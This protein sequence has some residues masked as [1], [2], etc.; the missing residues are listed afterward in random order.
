MKP[1]EIK[2]IAVHAVANAQRIIG[3]WLPDGKT[4]GHEYLARNPKRADSTP[5]S[6]SINVRTGEWADFATGDKGKDLVS[7]VAYLTDSTQSK[8]AEEVALFLGIPIEQTRP[9]NR[10]KSTL[11]DA[12]K[13]NASTEPKESLSGQSGKDSANDGWVC[14]M[15]IP[16]SAPLPPEAHPKHG[17]PDHRYPYLSIDGQVNYYHDRY[18]P[19]EADS[20]KQFA[21]LTL[22]KKNN[23]LKWQ[24]KAPPVPRPLY[25][26]P[27]LLQYPD[28]WVWIVEGE[29]AAS[30]LGKLL[31]DHPVLCWQGGS[32]AVDKSDFQ[33]LRGRRVRI[34]PD[35]DRPGKELLRI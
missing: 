1:P 34:W 15:P 17:K 30:A 29:K 7:L 19:K 10:T 8:A 24:F 22:W 4:E 6:F 28:A 33:P 32:M 14:V 12:G 25:G 23:L 35:Y 18:E 9:Q 16:E 5:G 27:S 13:G 2:K 26:L 20:K 11:K 31:P 3:Y 21:P